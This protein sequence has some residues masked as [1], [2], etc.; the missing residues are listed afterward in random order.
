M[1]VTASPIL[2][3][4]FISHER[5]GYVQVILQEQIKWFRDDDVSAYLQKDSD[6]LFGAAQPLARYAIVSRV[7]VNES[8]H[9]FIWTLHHAICDAVSVSECLSLA[10]ENY[11]G[12]S[13]ASNVA[14]YREFIRFLQ[15][16]DPRKAHSF[17]QQQLQDVHPTQFPRLPNREYNPLTRC[18]LKLDVN[19]AI[20]PR[21]GATRAII[22]RA[23]WALLLSKLSAA[24]DVLFG[25]VSYG[26]SANI[27]G[28]GRMNGPTI[29]T[30][31]VRVSVD[32]SSSVGNFLTSLTAQYAESLTH[33]LVGVSEIRRNLVENGIGNCS[34]Q[35]LFAVQSM[36]IEE[37]T[38]KECSRLGLQR[39]HSIGE[40]ENHNVAIALVFTLKAQGYHLRFDYDPCLMDEKQAATITHQLKTT[41]NQLSIK[42]SSTTLDQI[43]SFSEAD[44]SQI[45]LWNTVKPE[46]YVGCLQQ[47]LELQAQKNPSS[48]AVFAWDG[49]LNYSQLDKLSTKLAGMLITLGVQVGDNVA[50]CCEKS[51]WVIVGILGILKAGGAYVPLKPDIPIGRIN[52][53]IETASLRVGVFSRKQRNSK[54]CDSQGVLCQ[55]VVEIDNGL[56]LNNS[57]DYKRWKTGKQMRTPENAAYVLFTS[58]STGIPK[59]VVM[60]HSAL[61][62][63][64]INVGKLLELGSHTRSFQ[65]SSLAFDASVGE[66][67][68]ILIFGGC[69]CVPSDEERIN[70]LPLA[71]RNLQA[72]IALLVPSVANS[73]TPAET[74]SLRTL[75]PGGEALTKEVVDKWADS[76]RL[77][78]GYG[79]TESCVY[80]C[81]NADLIGSSDPRTIGHPVGS[82]LWIVE[83]DD[84][85]VLAPIG[86]I[87]EL[88]ISG[89]TLA[90][91]YLRNDVATRSAFIHEPWWLKAQMTTKSSSG[92]SKNIAYKTGDLA[93]YNSDGSIQYV[94]RKDNQV[95]LRGLRIELGE[96]ESHLSDIEAFS[97]VVVDL[98]RAG[99]CSGQLVTLVSLRNAQELIALSQAT[100]FIATF[101][102]V[103][104]IPNEI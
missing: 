102:Q 5:F 61:Y 104:R 99:P 52:H 63:S 33:E 77:V 16:S 93:Y 58:G 17:W 11:N 59:G 47:L 103:S 91:G 69:I 27:E 48:P 36:K 22:L 60:S 83:P 23:G 98:P 46:R 34:F 56:L 85:N 41:I 74:P 28:I 80:C 96:I 50:L 12:H 66:I 20:E 88:V 30:V 65:F 3:T 32:R 100:E 90:D 73:F 26:R 38:A 35:T 94:G 15:S 1:T 42:D 70:N 14:D 78:N 68:A 39:I 31:P 57:N 79:P 86:C 64:M 54:Q 76:V 95:K 7:G 43:S 2:R 9:Y 4:R 75:V 13:P 84:V 45:A 51:M 44:K 71:I 72:N 87:G 101:G 55:D 25:A 10:A 8:E 62:T 37:K 67:F 49:N 21:S 81:M 19:A 97:N 18:S 82:V 53:I 24:Q 40:I 29:T 92:G 6:F 89:A